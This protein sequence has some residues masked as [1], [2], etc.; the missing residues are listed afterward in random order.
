M[1]DQD[2]QLMYQM[3]T[4]DNIYRFVARVRNLEGK[5]IHKLTSQERQLAR[6]LRGLGLL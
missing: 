4:L 1:Y 6:Y 2:Y 3:T 5:D